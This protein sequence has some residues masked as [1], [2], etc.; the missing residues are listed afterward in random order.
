MVCKR[1]TV[2][3]DNGFY[4]YPLPPESPFAARITLRGVDALTE[5]ERIAAKEPFVTCA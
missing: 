2:E 1:F 3:S 4:D 5:I